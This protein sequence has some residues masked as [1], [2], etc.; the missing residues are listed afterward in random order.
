MRISMFECF[1]LFGFASTV[2]VFRLWFVLLLLRPL[3]ILLLLLQ[4]REVELYVGQLLAPLMPGLCNHLQVG[5]E[6]C[7]QRVFFYNAGEPRNR[8]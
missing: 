1:L 3:L 5:A 7:P 4:L 6:P 8:T 2:L